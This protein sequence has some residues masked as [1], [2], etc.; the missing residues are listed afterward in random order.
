M[1]T[2]A[3]RLQR[4]EAAL[5]PGELVRCWLRQAKTHASLAAYVAAL[6]AA[7]DENPLLTFPSQ[8]VRAVRQAHHGRAVAH[9]G[10]EIE[11]TLRAVLLRYQLV[12]SIN[13]LVGRE[14]STDRLVIELIETLLDRVEDGTTSPAVRE[15]LETHLAELITTTATWQAALLQIG[16]RYLAGE[17][18]LFANLSEHLTAVERQGA[19]LLARYQTCRECLPVELPALDPHTLRVAGESATEDLVG[20]LVDRA[21]EAVGILLAEQAGVFRLSRRRIATVARPGPKEWA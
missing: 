1:S 5:D 18:P 6:R 16:A 11:Q 13:D 15:R 10:A 9:L 4:L 12:M 20:D 19:T 17:H 8:V 3:T 2:H 21:D 14:S 7:P